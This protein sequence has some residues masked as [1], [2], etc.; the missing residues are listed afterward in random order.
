MSLR[1]GGTTVLEVFV[2]MLL[3]T[4]LVTL[5]GQALLHAVD[6]SRAS[7]ER[8]DRVVADRIARLILR[9]E[10]NALAPAEIRSTGGDSIRLRAVRGAGRVCAIGV[11]SSVVVDLQTHRAPDPA[12]D[13]LS[14]VGPLGGLLVL[15]LASI[16]PAPGECGAA[17]EGRP[18][19]LRT[20][21]SVEYPMV[22]L[23]VFETGAYHLA[24]GALRYRI[25]GGGRQPL[26]PEVWDEASTLDWDGRRLRVRL[27]DKPGDTMS[28][29]ILARPW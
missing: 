9:S 8:D 6:V 18:V 25:G 29:P 28:V 21:G 16:T 3:G 5:A 22:F 12:K 1:C 17:P 20:E 10:L 7:I 24:R 2:A 14:L 19:R 11:D 27:L 15:G 23:R 26:T 13:S 4:L